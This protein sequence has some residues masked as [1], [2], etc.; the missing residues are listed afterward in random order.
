M[1]LVSHCLAITISKA[2]FRPWEGCG[3]LESRPKMKGD[4]RLTKVLKSL[5]WGTFDVSCTLITGQLCLN[6]I[7]SVDDT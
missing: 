7:D 6:I 3:S 5:N 2:N 1:I 4:E